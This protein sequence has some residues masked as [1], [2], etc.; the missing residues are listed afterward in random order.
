MNRA[1]NSLLRIASR[2]TFGSSQSC[3]SKLSY[4]ASC[5][6]SRRIVAEPAPRMITTLSQ[7]DNAGDTFKK[8]CYFEMDFT[9]SEESTVYEAV[10]KFAAFDIGALVTVD[11][12]GA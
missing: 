6:L 11:A 7:M 2:S 3:T 12:K 5:L 4:A 1:A 8:S 9:I 10:Q